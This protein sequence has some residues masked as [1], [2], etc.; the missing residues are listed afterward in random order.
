MRRFA[1]LAGLLVLGLLAAGTGSA[2]AATANR[3]LTLAACM[4]KL[5]RCYSPTLVQRAYG[6][7]RLHEAGNDGRGTTIA[8]IM[9]PAANLRSSL[10]LQTRTYRLPAAHLTVIAPAGDPGP[11][12]PGA[13]LEATVDVEA[14]HL[15]APRAKLLGVAVPGDSILGDTLI[16]DPVALAID[17]AVRAGADV[18]SIS[19]L[20][21]EQPYPSLRAAIARAVRAGVPVV[22][23]SGDSGAAWPGQPGRQ[24]AYPASDPNVTAVGGTLL[25]LDHHGARL[26]PDIAW[27]PDAGGGASG[28]GV[29][30]LSPRPSWQ[31]ATPGTGRAG[32]SYPDISMLGAVSGSLVT[33]LVDPPPEITD[34]AFIGVGGTSVATP[35]FAGVLALA[36]QRAGR[37]LRAV[38]RTLYGLARTPGPDGIVDVVLGN[39]S[40]TNAAGDDPGTIVDGYLARR[41]YD[42]VT[43]LGTIDG[44]RF[45]RAL[46][47]SLPR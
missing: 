35:L 28:G 13:T 12:D 23:A 47:R 30:R 8:I 46:A 9:G 3:P 34:H 37:P 1:A 2:T 29:S 42:L 44:P 15:A 41:G 17:A 22:A 4:Q 36:R 24:P 14:A 26:L 16:A 40:V 7:D 45:V 43:G 10:A 21:L 31:A 6:L 33:A 27:G 20:G 39:N 11:L 25:T 19:Y 5:Y 32:R 18:I 38:N